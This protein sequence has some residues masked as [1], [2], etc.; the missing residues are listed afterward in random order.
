[1]RL[2]R[3]KPFHSIVHRFIY[4]H[5]FSDLIQERSCCIVFFTQLLIHCSNLNVVYG[6]LEAWRDHR[7]MYS[8]Q[9]NVHSLCICDK[10]SG[11]GFI[12]I[13]YE[14]S[15]CIVFFWNKC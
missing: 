14:F 13:L 4:Y 10:S 12:D 11:E 1:M 5:F 7:Y 8:L 9:G 15:G 6:I 3:N 2:H